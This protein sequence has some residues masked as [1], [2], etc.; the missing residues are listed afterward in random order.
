MKFLLNCIVW[1]GK[2]NACEVLRIWNSRNFS[3]DGTMHTMI[4]TIWPTDYAAWSFSQ[5]YW[6]DFFTENYC[7]TLGRELSEHL[8]LVT[9]IS[10]VN[11]FNP[12]YMSACF[13]VIFHSHQAAWKVIITL[14]DNLKIALKHK[15]YIINLF[16]SN[17][18]IFPRSRITQPVENR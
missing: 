11:L 3:I 2:G 13:K 12:E 6:Q 7:I 16:S 10:C 15:L 1:I 9:G 14:K 8:Q 4:E 17:Y 18:Y 5:S